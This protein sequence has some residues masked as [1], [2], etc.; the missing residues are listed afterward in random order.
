MKTFALPAFFLALFLPLAALGASDSLINIAPQTQTAIFSPGAILLLPDGRQAVIMEQ[1][2]NGDF[3]TDLEITISPEGVIRDGD[4]KGQ[5]AT[6]DPQ[7][8]AASMKPATTIIDAL[9]AP[10]KPLPANAGQTVKTPITETKKPEAKIPSQKSPGP[11]GQNTAVA[12]V[13]NGAGQPTPKEPGQLTLA[14]LLP[15]TNINTG[16]AQ[17]PRQLPEQAQK[18]TKA[19]EK[20]KVPAAETKREQSAKTAQAKQ[21]AHKEAQSK[22]ES[23]KKEPVKAAR[24]KAGEEMRIPQEAIK[25]GKLDFLEG[26]WQG[27]R[28]EYFTKRTIRECFCFGAGG[29][30]GKRRI[31]DKGR[32]CIGG[33]RAS[34]SGSGVLSVTSSGAACNDGERWGSAEMICRNNG[35]RTPCS[36][37]FRDANNG[38]QSYTIPFIRVDS[39]GR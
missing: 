14:E 37:V 24:P 15:M 17:P 22:Q 7:F 34:L 21:P 28:P 38:R 13:P 9:K 11:T 39:C 10:A 26:C 19:P 4:I 25:S 23:P 1:L 2:A 18:T 12:I 27:T 31:Y 29:K 35:P 8:Y 6:L 5:V 36:W 33:T 3:M 20:A 30:S 16:K 32:M